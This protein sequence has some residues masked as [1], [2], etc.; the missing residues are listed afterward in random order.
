MNG[1]DQ[2]EMGVVEEGAGFV[3]VAE[4]LFFSAHKGFLIYNSIS[5]E[6]QRGA[7]CQHCL[8]WIHSN[9]HL[10]TLCRERLSVF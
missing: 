5:L 10:F 1:A 6:R 2:I 8:S 3:L 7:N 4:I 9:S